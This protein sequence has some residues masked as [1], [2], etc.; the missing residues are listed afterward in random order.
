MTMNPISALTGATCDRILDDRWC[1][2]S[3]AR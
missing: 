1:A 2:S 3:A